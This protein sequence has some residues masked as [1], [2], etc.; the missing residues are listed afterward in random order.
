MRPDVNS[1]ALLAITPVASAADERA[2]VDLPWAL[3]ADDPNWRPPLKDEMHALIGGPKRNPWFL[4][5]RA[6]NF[7]R[8]P[9]NGTRNQS[10]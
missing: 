9:I 4:H 2:F 10:V 3:Y 6:W 1:G 8:T 5:A 7:W